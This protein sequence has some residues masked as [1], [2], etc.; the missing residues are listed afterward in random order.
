M[1][2][3][4]QVLIQ[5]AMSR[6]THRTRPEI[7]PASSQ[8]RS[9]TIEVQ[10]ENGFSIVRRCDFD[11]Q[12]SIYGTEHCF[13]V[14]DPHGYELEITVDFSQA[15]VEEVR[16]RTSGRLTLESTYWITTAEG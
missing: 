14:R 9:A 3:G 11:Q 15:C 12:S 5:V 4:K 1:E 2:G 7:E 8:A 13:V 16:Q 10:T 6:S